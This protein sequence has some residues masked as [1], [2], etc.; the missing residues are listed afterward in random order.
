M[1]SLKK[2]VVVSNAQTTPAPQQ[3]LAAPG[4]PVAQPEDWIIQDRAPTEMPGGGI[5]EYSDAM[6]QA[7]VNATDPNSILNQRAYQSGLD[8][9]NKRGLMNSSAAAGA[10][11]G[12]VLDRAAPMAQSAYAGW[13]SGKAAQNSNWLASEAYNR[14]YVGTLAA[15]PIKNYS[16][17]LNGLMQAATADPTLMTPQVMSGFA[18]FFQTLNRDMLSSFKYADGTGLSGTKAGG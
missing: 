17:A 11:Y 10:A 14:D 9:A 4:Q 18:S 6:N 12:E 15:L 13:Q 7:V 16:D 2:P 1:S 5:Q 3:P 8:M